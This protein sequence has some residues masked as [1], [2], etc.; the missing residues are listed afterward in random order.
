MRNIK[1]EFVQNVNL[2]FIIH[3]KYIL[4]QKN[5]CVDFVGKLIVS[6]VL[7]GEEEELIAMSKNGQVI[8]TAL[9]TISTL[10]R[11]TQGVTIMKMREGDGIA[12]IA[13][14]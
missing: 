10:G 6:K 12:S 3:K 7:S 5:N 1:I 9:D 14:L 11:Q 8:R 4:Q 13:C 2:S